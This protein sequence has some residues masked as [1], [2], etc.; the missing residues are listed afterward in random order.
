M[1]L[2]EGYLRPWT[3]TIIVIGLGLRAAQYLTNRSLWF[4]EALLALNVLHRPVGG[5][6]KPLDYNQGAPIGF[7]LLEKL[8]TKCAGPS[9]LVLRAFP[10][11]FG[12]FALLFFWR[13]ASSYV[14]SRAIPVALSLFALCGSLIYYS[15]EVKQYSSDAAVTVV[16]LWLV[17]KLA[18]PRLS[19]LNVISFSLAGAVAIWFSHP[20]S[21][22]LAGAGTAHLFFALA[23]RDWR[24]AGR[25]LGVCVAWALSFL[26]YYFVSLR[27]LSAHQALLDYWRNDFPPRSLWS[28]SCSSFL[29]D[30]FFATFNDPGKLVPLVAAPIFLLGCARL[31]R[32]RRTQFWLLA[33]PWPMTLLAAEL[34]KYPLGGRFFVC[35]ADSVS[36]HSRGSRGSR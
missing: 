19:L 14:S 18:A 29:T 11:A 20:A 31:A 7:L 32:T 1:D 23:E 33:A 25:L 10:L 5:L 24:R 34:H 16:L 27:T 8:A 26:A 21:F 17:L 3:W 6:F 30:R 35:A 28:L 13:V 9:E 22:L 12:A 15:S 4:D 36:C 2:S